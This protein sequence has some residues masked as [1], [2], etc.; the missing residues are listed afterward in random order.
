MEGALLLMPCVFIMHTLLPIQ[1]QITKMGR[2]L[3]SLKPYYATS[4]LKD[5]RKWISKTHVNSGGPVSP[6][7]IQ[8]L[9]IRKQRI[10]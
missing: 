9:G 10:P 6:P 8:G 7:K 2:L 4:K 1:L 5:K 3:S